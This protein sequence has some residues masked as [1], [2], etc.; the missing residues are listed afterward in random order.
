MHE[1]IPLAAT[2]DGEPRVRLARAALCPL[3]GE[4]PTELHAV[5]ELGP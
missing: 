1:H 5:F 4:A 2:P 3:Q